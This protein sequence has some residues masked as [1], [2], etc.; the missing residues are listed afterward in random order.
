MLLIVLLK[1]YHKND[2]IKSMK[3]L[4]VKK[5]ILKYIFKKKYYRTGKCNECGRCCENIYVNHG[6]KGFIKTEEEFEKLKLLNSFYRSLTCTGQDEI[7]LLFKCNNLD[8]VTRKCKNHLF[9][10]PICR[11]YPMEEI[12]KMGGILSQN[13]GYE[14]KPIDSFEDI[15]KKVSK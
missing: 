14:L 8:T 9:R 15:L 11:N 12:F 7:G 3:L 6:K 13:C 1:I 10:P 2:R 4:D 5:F